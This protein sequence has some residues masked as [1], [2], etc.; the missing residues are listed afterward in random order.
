MWDNTIHCILIN[1][2]FQSINNIHL[3]NKIVE[4]LDPSGK[5]FAHK[6]YRNNCFITEKGNI[7]KDLKVFPRELSNV[8]L[9]DNTSYAFG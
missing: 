9:I 3:N 1:L 4:Y 6:V 2:C 8:V 5:L 7:I